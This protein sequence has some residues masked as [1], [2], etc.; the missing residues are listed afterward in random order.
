MATPLPHRARRS[1]LQALR[2]A[3]RGFAAWLGL[4]GI[5]LQALLPLLVAAGM[6]EAH[7]APAAGQSAIHPHLGHQMP[8]P[9]DPPAGHSHG[10][11]AHCILCLGLH[12]VGPMAVPGGVI[13]VLPVA[14]SGSI[15]PS[16]AALPD[17]ARPPAPYA[18][19]A[20]PSI[21]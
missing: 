18:S 6:A 12:A 14:S 15:G 1:R 4:A 21:G 9:H 5:V 20:P 11:A 13:L 7:A 3:G 2:R 8:A 16:I 19:R 17:I 10:Q